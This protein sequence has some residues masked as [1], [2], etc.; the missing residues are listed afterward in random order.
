M[1]KMNFNFKMDA[2]LAK[3][4][5]K[6]AGQYSKLIVVEGIKAVALKGTAKV[7][8]TAFDEGFEGVKKLSIEEDII[9]IDNSE[10]PKKKLF[11]KKKKNEGEE[12]I[13]E[14]EKNLDET[15]EKAKELIEE[16]K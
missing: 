4:I 5:G 7:V 13:D 16:S 10:K 9:G 1:F 11:S 3:K 6:K 8:T 2:D 14:A 12:L 15:L